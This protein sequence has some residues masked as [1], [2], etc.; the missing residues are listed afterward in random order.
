MAAT[1]RSIVHDQ[2]ADAVLPLD[3][4]SCGAIYRVPRVRRDRAA[5]TPTRPEPHRAGAADQAVVV[6][7]AVIFDRIF[8][9]AITGR[10]R[11]V[12]GS[13]ATAVRVVAPARRAALDRHRAHVRLGEVPGAVIALSDAIDRLYWESIDRPKVAHWLAAYDLVRSVVTPHP[14]SSWARGLPDSV[15]AGPPAGYTD[16][17]LDDEFPLSMFFEVSSRRC[18]LSSRRRKGSAAPMSDADTSG[19]AIAGDEHERDA[20][21]RRPA[22]AW[23]PSAGIWHGSRERVGAPA[24]EACDLADQLARGSPTCPPRRRASTAPRADGAA[25]VASRADRGG[26][27]RARTRADRAPHRDG[28]R[29]G[30]T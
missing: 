14:A 19:V 17:V 13:R 28:V 26:L 6:Q 5:T 29:P 1:C 7:D 22:C 18:A 11:N 20:P 16:A 23:S 8:R 25:A 10:V 12:P 15:L 9:F 30:T 24:L 21:R 27:P 4:R 3:R 2:A